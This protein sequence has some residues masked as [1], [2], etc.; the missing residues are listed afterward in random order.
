MGI[1]CKKTLGASSGSM[2]HLAWME[3]GHE[4]AGR[5]YGN[6]QTVVNNWLLLEGHS[7]GIGDT[8]SDP[9]TYRVIQVSVGVWL[10]LYVFVCVW[11]FLCMCLFV[12][13][14]VFVYVF[15]CVCTCLFVCVCVYYYY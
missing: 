11:L 8:I 14:V 7:I 3:L 12:Y 9:N 10:C 2:M 4:I 6:I 13:V 1:L 15:V 5:L